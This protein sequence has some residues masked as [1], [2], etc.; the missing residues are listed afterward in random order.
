[1]CKI[2]NFRIKSIEYLEILPPCGAFVLTK[3]VLAS[4]KI[5]LF[6]S[7]FFASGGGGQVTFGTDFLTHCLSFPRFGPS[8]RAEFT[9]DLCYKSTDDV[10]D[11]SL[12]GLYCSV[13]S[14]QGASLTKGFKLSAVQKQ[15]SKLKDAA[16]REANYISFA[17]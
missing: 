13:C 5:A 8:V 1:M 7:I 4:V 3:M 15:R 16:R 14:S 12:A 10:T 17:R 11:E 9:L 6:S 2:C